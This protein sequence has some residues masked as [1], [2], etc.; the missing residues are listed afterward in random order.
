[1]FSGRHQMIWVISMSFW[2]S[3]TPYLLL[4]SSTLEKYILYSNT[5]VC[6][7]PVTPKLTDWIDVAGFKADVLKIEL[8]L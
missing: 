8:A 1:M 6:I 3:N 7:G 5:C 2:M 4:L